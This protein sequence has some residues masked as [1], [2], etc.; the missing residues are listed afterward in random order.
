MEIPMGALTELSGRTGGGKT[1]A[2][3][4][5]LAQ[6]PTLSV[7]WIEESFTLYPC[8]LPLHQVRMESVL[9]IESG[10]QHALWVV[11]QCL[12]SQLFGVVVFVGSLPV[13]NGETQLRRLQLAAEKAGSAVIFLSE[14]ATSAGA[15]PIA[16]QIQVER[17]DGSLLL[18]VLKNRR[19]YVSSIAQ[20][21]EKVG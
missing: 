3:L 20:L 17:R 8:A 2:L 11:H 19:S 5:F 9:L 1:E 15:W 18:N 6:N 10:E 12:K 14:K 4:G 13:R 16:L 21:S 7:A